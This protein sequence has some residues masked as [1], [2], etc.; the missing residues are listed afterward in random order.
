V[1]LFEEL[2]GLYLLFPYTNSYRGDNRAWRQPCVNPDIFTK[3]RCSPQPI[4]AFLGLSGQYF[5]LQPSGNYMYH[6]AFCIYGS[7]MILSISKD[8]FLEQNQQIYLCNGEVLCFLCG[9]D[10]I[11]KCYLDELRLQRRS[12][13]NGCKRRGRQFVVTIHLENISPA[14]L[15]DS[16]PRAGAAGR[17]E[18]LVVCD[19]MS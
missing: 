15:Q 6:C 17:K 19:R 11:L 16:R 2:V 14:H 8:H 4:G 7:C 5:N 3:N 12:F 1:L 13:P 10:C 18:E 9:T